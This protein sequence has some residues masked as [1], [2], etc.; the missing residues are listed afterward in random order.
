MKKAVFIL[1]FILLAAFAISAEEATYKPTVLEDWAKQASVI[2]VFFLYPGAS[3]GLRYEMK[4]DDTISAGGSINYN[5]AGDAQ[6]YGIRLECNFYPQSHGLNA[7]FV[8]PFAGSYNLNSAVPGAVFF[9]LGAQGGYRWIFD[10]I[11]LAP[12]VMIQYGIGYEGERK[13]VTGSGGFIY[14]LGLSAGYAF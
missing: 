5:F 7:W 12:R 2:E 13:I 9:S 4:I 6:S 10:Y 1:C 14:A 8:G 3:S 11:T